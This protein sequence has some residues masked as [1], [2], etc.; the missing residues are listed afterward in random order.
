MLIYQH[1]AEKQN[2][3]VIYP[4]K[5]GKKNWQDNAGCLKYMQ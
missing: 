5:F 1:G 4:A 3:D 2:P